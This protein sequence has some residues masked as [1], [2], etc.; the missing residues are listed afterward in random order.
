MLKLVRLLG[1]SFCCVGELFSSATQRP[2]GQSD[3]HG[4]GGI[5]FCCV[6]ELFSSAT[7]RPTGQSDEHGSGVREQQVTGG[8]KEHDYSEV[9]RILRYAVNASYDVKNLF[10]A[11]IPILARHASTD[12]FSLSWCCKNKKSTIG[13]VLC[14][15][16]ISAVLGGIAYFLQPLIYSLAVTLEKTYFGTDICRTALTSWFFSPWFVSLTV[17]TVIFLFPPISYL[18]GLGEGDT[19]AIGFVSEFVYKLNG[20][21]DSPKGIVVAFH[22]TSSLAATLLDL[23]FCLRKANTD[24][25]PEIDDLN[26]GFDPSVHGGFLQSIEASYHQFITAITSLDASSEVFF[27]GH[28]L[29]GALALL[30]ATVFKASEPGRDRKVK[31]LTFSAPKVGGKGIKN[32]IEYYLDSKEVLRCVEVTDIVPT[33]PWFCSPSACCDALNYDDYEYSDCCRG[34]FCCCHD[35]IGCELGICL[36][37]CC[38]RTRTVCRYLWRFLALFRYFVPG[39]IALVLSPILATIMNTLWDWVRGVDI[40]FTCGEFDFIGAFSSVVVPTMVTLFFLL[41]HSHTITPEHNLMKRYESWKK[42]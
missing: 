35:T 6:G 12:F 42:S 1:I 15:G 23:K 33:C 25:F 14:R 22:G 13:R 41:A 2:T 32:I 11:G 28:S 5:S 24:L 19:H 7:Q 20:T 16:I 30:A 9:L 34:L 4:S 18:L 29:G 10:G 27:T 38:T 37:D 3:E 40:V 17:G 26:H 39:G 21:R 8:W 31:V 36:E